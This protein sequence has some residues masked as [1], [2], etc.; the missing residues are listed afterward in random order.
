ME[1]TQQDSPDPLY[2]PLSETVPADAL[3]K[4]PSWRGWIHT[5]VLPIVVA[6]GIILI[7]LAHGAIP[8]VAASIFFASSFLLFGNS[9]LYH[10]F[11]WRP[12][13]KITLKRIDHA[14]I[15]LLIAGSYTPMAMLAL[16][17]DKGLVLLVAVWIGAV[18]GISFRIFWINAPRWL[19]VPLYVLLSW[20]AMFYVVDFFSFNAVAMSLILIGGL[21]Y[22]AGAVVY[23][24]KKPNPFPGHFGF[25]EI[26][27]ALTVIAFICHWVAV[28]Q[29]SMQPLLGSLGS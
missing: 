25:H 23:G 4:K 24:I 14:N 6:G 2:L 22:T 28:L 1:N 12:K 8:K 16:P 26:F 7:V 15:F 10:R 3:E 21:C 11:N 27:H 19:Y 20:A 9:A 17:A 13:V 5:G 18:L 29:V